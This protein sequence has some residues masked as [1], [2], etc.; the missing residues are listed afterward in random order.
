M[1]EVSNFDALYTNVI[2]TCRQQIWWFCGY[3]S[4]TGDRS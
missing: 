2:L 3:F 1:I 4:G